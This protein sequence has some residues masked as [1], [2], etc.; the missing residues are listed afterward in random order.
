MTSLS[1]KHARIG[2]F[3]LETLT[4]GMYR[5]PLDALREYVQN[6]FDSIRAAERKG[7]IKSGA[8]RIRIRISEKDQTLALSDNGLGVSTADIT[9][10]IVNIGM[11]AK[12]LG[13]DAG[14]RGI[15]RLAGIAYCDKLVFRTQSAYEQDVSTITFDADAL[16]KAMSPKNREIEDL[17][18]VIEKHTSIAVE[19]VRKK[20]H[21]FEVSMEGI[22]SSGKSFLSV[23][24]VRN[25]LEQVAPLP[26]DTQS[27]HYS[28]EFY[29]WVE[30][31]D[32]ELPEVS[33]IIET[34]ENSSYELFK[35]YKKITY[36]TAQNKY[37]V[38]VNGI[39]FFPPNAT[40]N[41][42]FWIW[43]AETNCP[44]IIGDDSVAGLRLRKSNIA[45]GLSERMTDVFR[46]VSES[47]A[48][49]NR[50][51][52]GEVHIQDTS[53]IPN[54]HRDDF[55]ETPE[56]VAI[57]DQLIQFAKDRSKEAYSLSDGRNADIEKLLL[58]ADKQLNEFDKRQR[59]GFASKSEQEN[60]TCTINKQISKL[61]AAEKADRPENDRKRIVNKKRELLKAQE[62]ISKEVTFAAKNLKSSLDKKQR[63]V[64]S[65]IL[66]LL[67]H[68]LDE[69]TFEK[70][71][72][73]ILNKYQIQKN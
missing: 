45:I 41:S 19:K 42:P 58:T 68:V 39:K 65:E 51:F 72:N 54:A 34:N 6:A 15:G 53:V 37:K 69:T 13:T 43:Y 21:F 10:M 57:R 40:R 23:R 49:F 35:P 26:L 3:V 46:L 22:N 59:T 52:M 4:T 2:A 63:K 27:F 18:F 66:E 48:R 24:E 64:I 47:Y 33:V 29:N 20:E 62:K 28:K 25:Y 14:F 7:I 61:E 36:T 9:T 60:F 8:G 16:R 12:N 17:S 1:N 55:E 50:Y 38:H 30:S 70:A 31:A 44:G 32:V 67:Y 56:W 5:N 73:A 71:R 11:S